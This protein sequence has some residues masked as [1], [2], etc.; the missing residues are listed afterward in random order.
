M[1][2]AIARH[3][4]QQRAA[5]VAPSKPAGNT[6]G[7]TQHWEGATTVP[8]WLGVGVCDHW[9][10]KNINLELVNSAH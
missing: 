2:R 7:L 3:R 8:P 5:S 10:Y 9:G 6:G 4:A 1:K